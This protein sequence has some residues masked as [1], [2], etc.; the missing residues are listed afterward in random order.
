MWWRGLLLRLALSLVHGADRGLVIGGLNGLSLCLERR[1]CIRL[2]RGFSLRLE[3]GLGICLWKLLVKLS[4]TEELERFDD[5]V[6]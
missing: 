5:N 2:E 3:S 4:I 6:C 1:L